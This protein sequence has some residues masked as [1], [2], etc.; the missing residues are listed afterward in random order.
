MTIELLT[1]LVKKA[2]YVFMAIPSNHPAYE[3]AHDTWHKLLLE[4]EAKEA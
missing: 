4:L 3:S 2:A 1:E